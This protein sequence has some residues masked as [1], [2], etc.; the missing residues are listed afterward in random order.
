MRAFNNC[1][2]DVYLAVDDMMM[3]LGNMCKVKITIEFHTEDEVED[4]V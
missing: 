2:K 3:N 4:D 1:E